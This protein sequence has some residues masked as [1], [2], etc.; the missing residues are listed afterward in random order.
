[1]WITLAWLALALI[2]TPPALAAF[3]PKLR[4]RMY[5]VEGEGALGLII[6]H[7]GLLFLAVA[8]ACVFA[9]FDAPARPLAVIVAAISVLGFLIFYVL[10]ASPKRLR[11]IALVDA[12]GLVPLG[13]VIADAW[14]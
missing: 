8:A 5:G 3:S 12:V 6:A 2:H 14:L 10:A 1:M 11:A 9:A 7:R 4:K 13:A